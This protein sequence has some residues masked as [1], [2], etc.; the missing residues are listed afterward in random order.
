MVVEQAKEEMETEV[1]EEISASS[2]LESGATVSRA[3]PTPISL[4]S[5]AVSF[6]LVPQFHTRINSTV[7]T[8]NAL[9]SKRAIII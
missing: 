7:E 6:A 3:T 2:L 1:A 9:F 4:Y 5:V 8:C